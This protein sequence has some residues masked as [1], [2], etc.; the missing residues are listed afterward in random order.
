MSY[1]A[2]WTRV[3]GTGETMNRTLAAGLAICALFAVCAV[4]A[5]R[6]SPHDP[7][8][9]NLAA[10]LQPPSA[11]HPM[12]TD[13]L[14]RD[15]LSRMLHA[16]GVS[17]TVGL[18]SVGIATV[19]G[20]TLGLIAGFYGGLPDTLIMRAVDIMLCF[21]V[22][23]LIL[24]VVAFLKPNVFNIMVIIGLTSWPGL[25]RYVRGEVLSLRESE[26]VR[27][28]VM[29][30]FGA[31]RLL[32]VHILPNVLV[33][34]V[35]TFSLGVG[36]AILTE[37]ALSFLGLG[38]QPPQPSWGNILLAGKEYIH[39][40]WWLSVFPGLAIFFAVIGFTLS[41]EGIR[42]WLNPRERG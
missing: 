37:S 3:S 24:M 14:G 20:T 26:F 8:A 28:A 39:M 36:G 5:G 32:F 42:Q 17:L 22:F 9:Q 2:T 21:P 16:A 23:F 10:R 1:T 6:L 18:V 29:A 38:V 15:V 33:P 40:A 12:G 35:V 7:L 34:V 19:I 27:S 31:G 4:F 30:G 41:G 11:V 25:A 13:E